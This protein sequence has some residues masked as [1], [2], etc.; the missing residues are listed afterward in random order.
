MLI[1]VCWAVAVGLRKR[2]GVIILY[3]IVIDSSGNV[4]FELTSIGM[5][6]L[7]PFKILKVIRLSD[8][9]DDNNM[10]PRLSICIEK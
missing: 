8:Y 6:G 5:V 4:I 9:R 3:L 7:L 2:F 10:N 1:L